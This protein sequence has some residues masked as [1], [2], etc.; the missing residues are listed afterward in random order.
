M[1][2]MLDPTVFIKSYDTPI[3]LVNTVYSY[4]TDVLISKVNA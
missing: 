4:E 1:Y 3:K 2:R